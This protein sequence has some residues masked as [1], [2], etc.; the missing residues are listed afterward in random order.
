MTTLDELLERSPVES[1][2]IHDFGGL[3]RLPDVIP[4][5]RDHPLL[6]ILI[7]T[8]S[9][10]FSDRSVPLPS[11]I[12]KP[13]VDVL[14]GCERPAIFR[15]SLDSVLQSAPLLDAFGCELA[16]RILGLAVPPPS[17]ASAVQALL[18][19]DALEIATELRLRKYCARW[20]LY[21]R[22]ST[23][24]PASGP[25]GDESYPRAV[26]RSVL[27]CLEQW[28]EADD[29]VGIIRQ[30]AGVEP[31][32]PTG[33]NPTTLLSDSDAGMALSRV[34]TIRAL[35]A[36]DRDQTLLHLQDA[37]R[38]LRPAQTE[39]SE[40]PDILVWSSIVSLLD[41]LITLGRVDDLCVI[42]VIRENTRELAHLDPMRYHWSGNRVAASHQAWAQLSVQLSFA[43]EH[44]SETSWYHAAETVHSIVNLYRV[45]SSTAV[46]CRSEDGES[47]HAIIAP[48]LEGGFAQNAALLKH[49]QDHVE[50]LSHKTEEDSD[51]EDIRSELE[52]A[53]QLLAQ[54][55]ERFS[56]N[57]GQRPKGVAD[58]SLDSSGNT[59]AETDRVLA[60]VGQRIAADAFSLGTIVA[61]QVYERMREAFSDSA[62]YVHEVAEATDF[63]SG[64]LVRFIWDRNQLGESDAPYLYDDSASE[65]DLAQDLHSF[66]RASGLLGTITT[67]IRR[68]AG[69]RVDV[70][71]AFPGFNLYVE[72]KIDAT[73]TPLTD[74]QAYLRQAATYT[75]V[76]QRIS[77]L[78]VLRL[79]PEKRMV[80]PHFSDAIEV[81]TVNDADG[82]PRHVGVFEL[83]G[84]R[85]KPSSM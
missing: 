44:L 4:N 24:D 29:L 56:L 14:C 31:A 81:V 55:C 80:P 61:D 62:D 74:K 52:T 85:T 33:G 15:D 27:A 42:D 40:R 35:R 53:E 59:S 67:E 36:K 54:A 9:D 73:K 37:A 28:E 18:A 12:S 64:L 21:A 65:E 47:L 75:T 34:E 57:K 17:N 5:L 32:S 68:V 72:L 19:S 49:L 76:D 20:D 83:P 26:L 23:Y 43:Q 13:L 82:K 70:Q 3:E 63:V 6:P 10:F 25:Q 38:F 79:V 69:G 77:F 60:A 46:L 8:L 41:Q 22:L 11:G 51:D 7:R 50:E 78:V 66:L 71:F 45:S 84:A 39:D 30:I 16:E 48:V 58:G 1:V 2:G